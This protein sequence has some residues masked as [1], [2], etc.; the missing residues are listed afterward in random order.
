MPPMNNDTYPRLRAYLRRLDSAAQERYAT[1]CGT[2][3][4]YLRKA[5]S[6][7]SRFDV[8]LV[9]KLVK[10][11]DYEV[12]PAELRPDVDWRIFVR[13][14]EARKKAPA[15]KASPVKRRTG[16]ASVAVAAP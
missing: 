6:K 9:E 14:L 5:M 3:L 16:T 8:A 10:H 15:R 2:S 7:E 12:P 13:A 4:N 11:S 1:K